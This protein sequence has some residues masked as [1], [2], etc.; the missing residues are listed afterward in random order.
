MTDL[1]KKLEAVLFA[2]GDSVPLARL[3]LSFAVQVDVLIAEAK[4]L[5]KAYE[6]EQRG[7]RLLFLEDRLQLCTN[8]DFAQDITRTL[9]IRRQPAL[10]QA[11]LETLAVI[12]YYQPATRAVIEK[13]RGV[14]SSYSVSQLEDKG[15]IESCGNLDV[16]GRPTL[17]RTTDAFLRVMRISSLN[18]L[19]P[20]PETHDAEG[21]QTLRDQITKLRAADA[22]A[23]SLQQ[24]M[25][26]ADASLR[27]DYEEGSDTS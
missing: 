21:E 26:P 22:A 24:S 17:F 9:G 7:I 15:L 18:D 3:S 19:P 6:T 11:A 10:S 20:L 4:E 16:P 14:D 8:P 5:A 2:A 13:Y 25:F 23:G 1:Q 12:A 27:L